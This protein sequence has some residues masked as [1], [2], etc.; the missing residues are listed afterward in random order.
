MRIY[1][2]GIYFWLEEYLFECKTNGQK[3]LSFILLP[4]SLLYACV[5]Y[6][7]RVLA[8]P[9]DYQIP[10]VSIGN[11]SLGGSGKTPF[12]VALARAL[13]CKVCVILR[14]YGRASRGLVQ[15]SDGRQILCGVETSGD[16]AM[17][18][19]QEVP[20][21]VVLVSEDRVEAIWFAKTLG[22]ECVLLD[23][24]FSKCQIKKLDIL[25]KPQEILNTRVLPS[26]CYREASCCEKYADIVAIDGVDFTREV[27]MPS[28][29]SN[30]SNVLLLTSISKPKRLDAYLPKDIKKHYLKDH[31]SMSAPQVNALV[32]EYGA[33]GVLATKKD[34][35]KLRE[36]DL[37]CPLWVMDLQIR[38]S[39]KMIKQVREYIKI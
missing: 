17:L 23:D 15:V 2:S 20:S 4:L 33:E 9:I 5:S 30:P 16:E 3:I 32:D 19:A 21:A 39:D 7:R 29:P 38:L 35:V 6:A 18:I 11:L 25:L 37:S 1:S 28:L 10:V 36:L 22:V 14:G 31:Q 24:G 8:K 27:Q 13:P 34:A 26:G 12:A